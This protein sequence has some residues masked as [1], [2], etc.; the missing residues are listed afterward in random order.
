MS[1][2]RLFLA[3]LHFNQNAGREQAVTEEGELRW[4]VARPRGRRGEAVARVVKAPS[5]RGKFHVRYTSKY[6]VCFFGVDKIK[7]VKKKVKLL[8]LC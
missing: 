8:N 6:F 5:S 2:F 3:A 1:L 4:A 7:Q